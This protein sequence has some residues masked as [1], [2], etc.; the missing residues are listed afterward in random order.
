MSWNA[1]GALGK[2]II[3]GKPI[4]LNPLYVVECFRSGV[5]QGIG[6]LLMS[7]NPLYVVECFRSSVE[8]KLRLNLKRS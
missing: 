1:F 6:C 8:L 5:A 2:S 7:L 3:H 4:G